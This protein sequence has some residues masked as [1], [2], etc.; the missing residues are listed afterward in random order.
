[1][2]MKRNYKLKMNGTYL[3]GVRQFCNLGH[4]Q[5]KRKATGLSVPSPATHK[6]NT[7]RAFHCNPLP[8]YARKSFLQNCRTPYILLRVMQLLTAISLCTIQPLAAQYI[9]GNPVVNGSA[10]NPNLHHSTRKKL[11]HTSSTLQWSF[12]KENIRSMETMHPYLDGIAASMNGDFSKDYFMLRGDKRWTNDD[13]Q[14]NTVSQIKWGTF[15]ENFVVLYFGDSVDHD[16][17]NDTKW[18]TVNYNA[19][20]VSKM[21][22]AG[23]FKGVFLDDENYFVSSHGWQYDAAWYPGYTLTQVKAKCRE[24]GKAFMSALQF[25]MPDPLVILDFIWFGDHWNNYDESSGRQLL[26]LAFKDGML[27]AARDKDVHVEGNEMAYYYQETSMFTDIYNEFRLNKFSRYGASDLQTKYKTH[28]QIGHGLYPSLYYGLFRWPYSCTAEEQDIWWEHQLY[29]AL[30]TSD[31]Y[32]WIWSEKWD[33]FGDGSQALTPNFASIIRE[34]KTKINNQ[35]SINYDLVKHGTNWEGNL[36]TPSEKW[37]SI[38]APAISIT[39]PANKS[40]TAGTITI[41]TSVLKDVKTVEFFMN[42]MR[43]GVVDSPPFSL[44]VSGLAKGTYTIFVRAFDINHEHTT[45]APVVITVG[46]L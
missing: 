35:Q 2:N 19:A 28:V 5:A 34:V 27:E 17:F 23:R 18:S 39:S 4:G 16:F 36:V 37:H 21:L 25:N 40:K 32:V 10:I 26:W 43:V 38:S 45:S 41:K 7:L 3:L 14:L 20:M 13:I 33:W 1:M 8:A 15:T 11:I 12:V 44:P 22:K 29:N 46:G 6:P 24:R 31:Q 9:M 30:L 42:T